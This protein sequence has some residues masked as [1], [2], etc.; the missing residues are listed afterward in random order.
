M[1]T[2]HWPMIIM[3]GDLCITQFGKGF[4]LIMDNLFDLHCCM[5]KVTVLCKNMTIDTAM[6]IVLPPLVTPN[7]NNQCVKLICLGMVLD[8]MRGIVIKA[9]T[10]RGPSTTINFFQQTQ[11]T[12][13]KIMQVW[14]EPLNPQA[15]VLIDKRPGI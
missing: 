14:G 3:G 12:Q 6:E 4:L 8:V 15:I 11:V 7:R 13:G 1:L 2:I 9:T 10:H 5:L